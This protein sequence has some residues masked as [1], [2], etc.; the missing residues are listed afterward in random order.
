LSFFLVA[1]VAVA[2]L[3]QPGALV[4]RPAGKSSNRNNG[5]K[6]LFAPAARKRGLR[7]HF[8]NKNV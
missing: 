3:R 2:A 4:L 1:L 5:A 7:Y 6:N 8:E